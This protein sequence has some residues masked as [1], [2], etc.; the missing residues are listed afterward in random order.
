[1]PGVSRTARAGALAAICAAGCAPYVIASPSKPPVDPAALVP[2]DAAELCVLRTTVPGGTGVVRDNGHVVGAT[3]GSGYF[4]YRARP[5]AH[6]IA[7]WMGG[8]SATLD[9]VVAPGERVFLKAAL[10]GGLVELTR[11]PAP[12]AVAL[13]PTLPFQQVVSGPEPVLS[14]SA[15]AEPS[16]DSAPPPDADLRPRRRPSDLSYGAA[17]G[18]GVGVARVPP[19]TQPAPDFSAL[20]SLWVGIPPSDYVFLGLRVD[21]PYVGG[22]G[23]T[24]VLVHLA[25]FPAAERAGWA[26]DLM[27]FA[28][29]GL[30]LQTLLGA[31]ASGSQ[32][33]GA[34]RVGL[35]LE[36]WR[37]GPV[38]LG[39][40]VSGDM[41]RAGGED[42][43]AVFAGVLASVYP[44]GAKR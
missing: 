29:G 2:A 33:G 37:L 32:I 18:V 12:D 17:L 4:C 36:R 13:L 8:D 39:P 6:G 42:D 3:R 11:V 30:R 41:A 19:A 31:S 35:G 9:V 14:S 7:T 43:A 20:G 44:R 26:R 15:L 16:A 34:G 27:V 38:W 5:G 1:M 40:F 25:V 21:L 22:A 28:D 24:D 10:V 23:R